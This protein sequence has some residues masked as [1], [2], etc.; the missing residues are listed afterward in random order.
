[1]LLHWLTREPCSLLI[2]LEQK[3]GSLRNAFILFKNRKES[4]RR[5]FKHLHPLPYQG[6]PEVPKPF[7]NTSF[8]ALVE[9][10]QKS[11]TTSLSKDKF[12]RLEK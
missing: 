12:V 6:R 5:F 7:G 11:G 8:L 4:Q 10:D 2:I 9:T 3:Q 1:M